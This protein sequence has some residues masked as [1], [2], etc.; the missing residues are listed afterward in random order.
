MI[1]NEASVVFVPTDAA[2]ATIEQGH[3]SRSFHVHFNSY[4]TLSPNI[5]RLNYSWVASRTMK[6]VNV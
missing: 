5:S 3:C 4:A 2:N 1:C 6:T